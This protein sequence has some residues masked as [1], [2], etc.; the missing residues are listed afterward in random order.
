MRVQEIAKGLKKAGLNKKSW[1]K[2]SNCIT[3][4]Y[5]IREFNYNGVHSTVTLNYGVFNKEQ[6]G[7]SIEDV[8]FILN[9]MGLKT[10]NRNGIIAILK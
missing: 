7:K 8:I 10:E 5:E 9:S 6:K 3:G 1:N 4:D 2:K